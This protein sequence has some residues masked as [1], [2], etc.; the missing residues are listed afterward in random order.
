M[1]PGIEPTGSTELDAV[2]PGGG[3]RSGTIV[4]L[5]PTDVG[6]G[7]LRL[8]MPALASITRAERFVALIAPP[9]IPFAP[10]LAQQG[11]QLDRLL[12]VNAARPEDI[13][14]SF[15]Q[16]LRCESFGAAV[17]WP[18]LIRD[19][20]IRRLQLAAEAGRN[21]GFMY[22][23]P[24]AAREAS[25]AAVRI[26][27]QPRDNDQLSIEILKCRGARVGMSI[28]VTGGRRTAD[29]EKPEEIASRSSADCL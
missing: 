26:R 12:I 4:E 15:E 10:A 21:T 16:V 20:Q 17:A 5:M 2:L 27:L 1:P 9:Y 18:S 28:V 3:W 22:R 29:G 11:M 8:L 6:I 7:E 13:L 14:W 25:P 24:A 23:A 19:R